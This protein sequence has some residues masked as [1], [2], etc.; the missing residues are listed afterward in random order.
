[1]I[2]VTLTFNYRLSFKRV[3]LCCMSSPASHIPLRVLE[4]SNMISLLLLRTESDSHTGTNM[5]TWE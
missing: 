3:R 2:S 1:M 5:R 4:L